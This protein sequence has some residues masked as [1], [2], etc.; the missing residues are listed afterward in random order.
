LSAARFIGCWTVL[1]ILM[2][3][4]IFLA[5]AVSLLFFR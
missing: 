5:A 1:Y 3:F 2:F 4:A